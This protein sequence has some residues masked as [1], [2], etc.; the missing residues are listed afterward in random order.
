MVRTEIDSIARTEELDQE[1]TALRVQGDMA[2]PTDKPPVTLRVRDGRPRW[3]TSSILLFLDSKDTP[4]TPEKFFRD[5]IDLNYCGCPGQLYVNILTALWNFLKIIIFLMFVFV[6]VMAFGSAYSVS[7]S[8]QLMAT[9]AGGFIPFVFTRFFS[10]GN[11]A[12]SVDPDSVQ[13]KTQF[14]TVINSYEQNW[15]VFD[16][17]PDVPKPKA[18]NPDED[19]TKVLG[20]SSSSDEPPVSSST[21]YSTLASA[22]PPNNNSDKGESVDWDDTSLDII[23]DVST[24]GGRGARAQSGLG[25]AEAGSHTML[26]RSRRDDRSG[27]GDGGASGG[28]ARR[29]RPAE[30]SLHEGDDLLEV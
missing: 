10:R 6:V 16:I 4:Y 20:T 19:E 7:S 17:V 21:P 11:H 24:H 12:A 8:N 25:E 28:S 27:G 14:H 26:N 3:S 9:V 13:F 2:T 23:F 29:Y 18:A 30:A 15:P 5:T 22:N 1:N